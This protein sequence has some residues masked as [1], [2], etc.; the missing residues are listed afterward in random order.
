MAKLERGIR[1][2]K[3]SILSDWQM[4]IYMLMASLG[5][6]CMAFYEFLTSGMNPFMIACK[7]EA[8]C[9]ALDSWSVD[10]VLMTLMIGPW[11][12]PSE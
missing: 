2:I 6:L 8:V 7:S 10:Y 11:Y 9:M 12:Q 3:V 4:I 5:Q 1:L